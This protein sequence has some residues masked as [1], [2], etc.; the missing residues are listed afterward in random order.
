MKQGIIT[1]LPKPGKDKSLTF[2]SEVDLRRC[3]LLLGDILSKC[4]LTAERLFGLG[5]MEAQMVEQ[6]QGAG[7]TAGLGITSNR[8]VGKPH[9]VWFLA[10]TAAGFFPSPVRKCIRIV[11]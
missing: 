4:S 8:S 2:L 11:V 10:C 6:V 7:E 9:V 5:M 3:K 1:L